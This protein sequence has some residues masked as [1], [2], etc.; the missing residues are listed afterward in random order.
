MEVLGNTTYNLAEEEKNEER[1]RKAAEEAARKE[2]KKALKDD[3]RKSKDNKGKTLGTVFGLGGTKDEPQAK[4][5]N[6]ATEQLA[7]APSGNTEENTVAAP[8]APG[9]D[10]HIEV[11]S[12]YKSSVVPTNN[13][14]STSKSPA[15]KAAD[16]AG[17]DPNTSPKAGDSK[18]K[19]WLKSRFR[20]STNPSAEDEAGDKSF[21]G[22]AALTGAN[23]ETAAAKSNASTSEGKPGEDSMREVALAGKSEPEDMYGASDE[24]ASEEEQAV[25]PPVEPVPVIAR[26]STPSISS[27]SSSDLEEDATQSAA[28]PGDA[29]APEQ[30]RGRRGFRDRLLGLGLNKKAPKESGKSQG[31]DE[32]DNSSSKKDEDDFEEARD[33]FDEGPTLA[34]PPKLTPIASIG[35][36]KGSAGTA[37]PARDSRFSEEF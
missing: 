18:V 23:V 8:R 30:E 2:E 4:N 31:D 13:E 1:N 6:E 35:P 26:P 29:A 27:L 19:S 20:R 11:D 17:D 24:E 14:P 21:V 12:I 7:A 36:S 5:G 37:S 22:G 16:G 3:K 32:D 9:P 33:T 10:E 25:S 34:P 15:L 28:Q